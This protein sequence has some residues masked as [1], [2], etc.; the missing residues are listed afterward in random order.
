[1]MNENWETLCKR[2]DYPKLGYIIHRLKQAG[3]PCKF[4]TDEQG[5]RVGSFHAS[6]ILLIDEAHADAAWEI[7]GEKW[8][9][10]TGKPSSRGRTTLDDMPDDHPAFRGY[11]DE[12]PGDEEE[13]EHEF[14][15]IRDGWVG[16]DGRP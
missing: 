3:V 4:E 11:A 8:S 16:K 1:M 10:A 6:N 13:A 7:M 15:P 14:D 5:R 2:T 12:T 9:K